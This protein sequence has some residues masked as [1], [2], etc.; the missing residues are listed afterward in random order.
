[1]NIARFGHNQCPRHA[2]IVNL[3]ALPAA[4]TTS[5]IKLSNDVIEYCVHAAILLD[6]AGALGTKTGL[7]HSL[8]FT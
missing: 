2:G 3:G 4:S 1:M 7:P 8:N 6:S 5:G